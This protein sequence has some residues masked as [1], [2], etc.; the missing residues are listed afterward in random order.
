MGT[1]EILLKWQEYEK[2]GVKKDVRVIDIA[3]AENLNIVS[4]SP[5]F[6][7]RVTNLPFQSKNLNYLEHL[8][9]QHLQLIR[10]FPSP[11]LL[12]TLVGMTEE[13]HVKQNLTVLP[14]RPLT[15]E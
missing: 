3:E 2:D 12:T 13:D 9:A 11:S 1:P 10:S 4:C 5:L 6:Q 8:S 14:H 7:G 15:E